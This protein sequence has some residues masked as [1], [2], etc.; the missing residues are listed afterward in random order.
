MIHQFR[1]CHSPVSGCH[2]SSSTCSDQ[3]PDQA[4]EAAGM[5][6]TD[7]PAQIPIAC[8]TVPYPPPSHRTPQSVDVAN[9]G[10]PAPTIGSKRHRSKKKPKLNTSPLP[11]S[12]GGQGGPSR[13]NPTAESGESS[14]SEVRDD[15][16]DVIATLSSF[17][18]LNNR[19]KRAVVSML[20]HL[21][22]AE[23]RSRRSTVVSVLPPYPG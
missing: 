18:R 9:R 23:G 14:R 6:A 4:A 5:S 21:V 3:I 17:S 2:H 13:L 22:P 12:P 15:P 8:S 7:L 10:M 16:S 11:V 1:F 20:N 19:E